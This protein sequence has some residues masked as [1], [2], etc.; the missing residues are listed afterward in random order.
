MLT[1]TL[2]FVFCLQ[3]S[4]APPVPDA[5]GRFE[6]SEESAPDAGEKGPTPEAPGRFA[7]PQSSPAPDPTPPP[8][9]EPTADAGPPPEVVFATTPGDLYLGLTIGAGSLAGVSLT[10]NID[11]RWWF[12]TVVGLR[13]GSG[14]NVKGNVAVTASF[15]PEWGKKRG[16]NGLFVSA[17]SSVGWHMYE[18][19]GAAGYRH[20]TVNRQA[21]SFVDF[22]L[23]LGAAALRR[24]ADT[25][26]TYVPGERYCNSAL[27]HTCGSPVVL[28]GGFT[29]AGRVNGGRK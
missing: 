7:A 19:F 21:G 9:P 15:G 5:P 28:W 11:D 20:R 8:E 25:S 6:P 4:D 22:R 29:Y 27:G 24:I 23:G 18:L 13:L 1:S 17:S 10:Y 12:D 16:R 3:P 14:D 2:L 26:G